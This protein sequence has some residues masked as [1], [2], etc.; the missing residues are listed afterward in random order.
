[1]YTDVRSI[2]LSDLH[3]LKISMIKIKIQSDKRKL[4][5]PIA[6][7]I[8]VLCVSAVFWWKYTIDDTYITLRYSHNLAVGNGPVFNIGEKVEGYSCPIWGIFL[9]FV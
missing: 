2:T 5:T 6:I 4:F 9:G 8:T 7:A 1:M 3:H